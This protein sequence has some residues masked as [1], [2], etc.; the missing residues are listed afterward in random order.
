MCSVRRL[1]SAGEA[2][3]GAGRGLRAAC[4]R[5]SAD[6]IRPLAVSLVAAGVLAGAFPAMAAAAQP[7][8][9]GTA[10]PGVFY[11]VL[12]GVTAISADDAWAVGASTSFTGLLVH[13]NGTAWT[14][15]NGGPSGAV[16]FSSVAAVSASDIWAVGEVGSKTL[17]ERW[18]GTAWK[19]VTSP[20]PSGGAGLSGVTVLSADQAWAVGDTNSAD[21]LVEQWNG[22]AWKQ[23]PSPSP[24]GSHGSA[25]ASVAAVSATDAWAV[26]TAAFESDPVILKWNGSTWTTDLG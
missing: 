7:G 20:T 18:N 4:I 15:V 26:G 9:G 21:T 1:Q 25:L 12:K 10:A 2:R 14:P 17:I 5:V 22:T 3:L 6:V 16:G 13:W 11:G 23:V 8:P 24:G 19:Q